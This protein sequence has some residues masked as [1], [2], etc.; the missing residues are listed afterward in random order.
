MVTELSI[1][2]TAAK[3]S[4]PL[5]SKSAATSATGPIPAANE[6]LGKGLLAPPGLGVKPEVPRLPESKE[7]VTG[8]RSPTKKVAGFPSCARKRT[9]R[10]LCTSESASEK[11]AA[12]P[13]RVKRNVVLPP[14]AAMRGGINELIEVVPPVAAPQK[15]PPGSRRR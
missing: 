5:F 12:A 8:K 7:R 4:K 2:L 3:S 6:V 1:S 14:P 11:S 9:W 15:I 10:P 13:G